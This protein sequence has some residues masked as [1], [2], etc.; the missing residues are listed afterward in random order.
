V[1][2]ADQLL[3]WLQKVLIGLFLALATPRRISV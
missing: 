2:I 3:D 1:N